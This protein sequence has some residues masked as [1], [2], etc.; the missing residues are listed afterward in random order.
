MLLAKLPCLD[1]GFVALIDKSNNGL[2]LK[3]LEHE[4]KLSPSF[5][6]RSISTLTLLIKC[7]LFIQLNLSTHNLKI[8]NTGLNELEAYVPN[9][10][11][12][13]CSDANISNLI[14]QDIAQTTEALLINPSAYVADGC[15]P[16]ISQVMCPI[17]TYTTV[18][19]HGSLVEWTKY[20]SQSRVPQAV[21][22]YINAVNQIIDSE[23]R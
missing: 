5:H 14:A 6:L 20:C 13:G 9:Q 15:D 23:W 19:V 8:F 11:E 3:E 17:S 22:S 7:P 21:K 4:L 18:I 10:G 16:F 12:I 1:K 2:K